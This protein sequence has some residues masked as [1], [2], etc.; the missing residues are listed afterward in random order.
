MDQLISSMDEMVDASDMV[1]MPQLT[2]SPEDTTL[3]SDEIKSEESQSED[4]KSVK[5]RKSWGQELPTPKTNL[6]PRCV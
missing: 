4:R 5:K 2:I 6:P 3:Q 1:D